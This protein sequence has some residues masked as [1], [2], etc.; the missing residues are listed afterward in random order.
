M[1]MVSVLYVP[2]ALAV[3]PNIISYQLQYDYVELAPGP[4]EDIKT[5]NIDVLVSNNNS[6]NAL[7]TAAI[8][9][10]WDTVTS[11]PLTFVSGNQYSGT[12]TFSNLETP[13]GK[14]TLAIVANDSGD[15]NEKYSAEAIEIVNN[16]N[17]G[18]P[19]V[20]HAINAPSPNDGGS[21]TPAAVVID[22]T[23]GAT[24]SVTVT[25]KVTDDSRVLKVGCAVVKGTDLY[26]SNMTL[27]ANDIW[28]ITFNLNSGLA[29][30]TYN[31]V[32]EADD[33]FGNRNQTDRDGPGVW[34]TFTVTNADPNTAIP[35][36]SDVTLYPSK[37]S[38]PAVV[39]V[40][41][42]I[43]DHGVPLAFV[44]ANLR[45]GNLV[46]NGMRM[47][48]NNSTGRYEALYTIRSTFL[49]GDYDVIMTATNVNAM[50]ND[51]QHDTYNN[52]LEV[53]PPQTNVYDPNNPDT[54]NFIGYGE[55]SDLTSVEFNGEL[56]I[57]GEH[58]NATEGSTII[59]LRPSFLSNYPDGSYPL[60]IRWGNVYDTSNI[61]LTANR[62]LPTATPLPTTS[63]TPEIPQTGDRTN[64]AL[65][66]LLALTS[67]IVIATFAFFVRKRHTH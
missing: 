4:A 15:I 63:Q 57:E 5:V 29:N 40:S 8:K 43:D 37:V 67:C 1:A 58:F 46:Y 59:T 50:S 9:N 22:H 20:I 2:R 34:G 32:F 6:G 42:N 60:R 36:F 56:L 24:N 54:L 12:F 7:V 25:V 14:F 49:E 35:E 26:A 52:V 51:P 18:N 62:P 16:N 23:P 55:L 64:L 30:G 41:A 44:L 19:P 31:I 28:S 45:V 13:S 39:R 66:I 48:L 53:L 65:F 21:I 47:Y 11:A 61:V 38:K 27:T 3:T 17:D 33:Y 10:G